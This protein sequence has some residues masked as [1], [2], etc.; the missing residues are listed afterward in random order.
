MHAERNNTGKNYTLRREIMDTITAVK[1]LGVMV[2]NIL[3]SGAHVDK[4][5]TKANQIVRRMKRT[6]T[7]MGCKMFKQFYTSLERSL[8]TGGGA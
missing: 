4:V 6:S 1:D 7:Y 5:A 3:K 8:R 2:S